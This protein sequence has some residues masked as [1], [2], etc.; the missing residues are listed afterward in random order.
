VTEET[1]EAPAKAA[2]QRST[3]RVM[4]LSGWV[5]VLG[6]VVAMVAA[7]LWFTLATP[8]VE[9]PTP[10]K[11]WTG[12]CIGFAVGSLFSLISAYLKPE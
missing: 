11:E 7:A 9:M 6:I 5:V 12:I 8:L 3:I 2:L 4:L 1:T 10:L